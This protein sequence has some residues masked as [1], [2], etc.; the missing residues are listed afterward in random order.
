MISSK[1]DGNYKE[2]KGRRKDILEQINDIHLPRITS[3]EQKQSIEHTIKA[4]HF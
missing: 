1:E 2:Q 3:V 4:I